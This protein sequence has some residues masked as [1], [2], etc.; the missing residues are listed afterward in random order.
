MT[1]EPTSKS[2]SAKHP[3]VLKLMGGAPFSQRLQQVYDTL[4]R[5]AYE[6]FES[7]GRQDGQDLEDW[8]RAESELLN[9]MPVKITE[10]DDQVI[11]RAEVPGLS[12]QD[13]EVR[14]AP[15]RLIITGKREQ[16][17]DHEKR[18]THSETSSCEVVRMLDLSEE[19]DPDEVTATVQ[20]GT[21]EVVLPKAHPGKNIPDGV[22][23]A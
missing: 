12:D 3:A 11:V 2:Q 7:R 16:I 20:N 14:V 15:H 22:K 4:A 1:T 17:R 6:L 9:A 13:I 21:L 10:A 5:R 19:I 18:K 23:A 8:F